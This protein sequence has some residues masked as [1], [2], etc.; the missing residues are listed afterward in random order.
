VESPSNKYKYIEHRG[1]PFASDE[2]LDLAGF[3]ETEDFFWL[4]EKSPDGSELLGSLTYR[5]ADMN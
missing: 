3:E 2:F 1:I 5:V 4:T